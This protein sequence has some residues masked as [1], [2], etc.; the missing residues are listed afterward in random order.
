MAWWE[1]GTRSSRTYF[2]IGSGGENLLSKLIN[3]HLRQKSQLIRNRVH[4]KV[5][6]DNESLFLLAQLCVE[7]LNWTGE[8]ADRVLG[9]R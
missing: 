3:S 6:S 8:L 2:Y 9:I 4:D 7:T 1:F 5:Q